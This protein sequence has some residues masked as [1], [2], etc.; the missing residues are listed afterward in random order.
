MLQT[1]QP[2]KYFFHFKKIE[3]QLVFPLS[4]LSLSL[5]RVV[6]VSLSLVMAMLKTRNKHYWYSYIQLDYVEIL[7]LHF[8]FI[9]EKTALSMKQKNSTLELDSPQGKQMYN[10]YTITLPTTATFYPKKE[11]KNNR[12][13]FIHPLLSLFL[14][15]HTFL[16]HRIHIYFRRWPKRTHY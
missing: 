3:N 6:L 8:W 15:S 5:S 10:W 2:K 4:F 1:I 7:C 12:D 11:R 14:S 16:S 13:P 9:K